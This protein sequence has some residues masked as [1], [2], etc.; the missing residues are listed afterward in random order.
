M[1]QAIGGDIMCNVITE[2]EKI[3]STDFYQFFTWGEIR[4]LLLVFT[5]IRNITLAERLKAFKGPV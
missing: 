1:V 3:F 5:F 4:D 2:F